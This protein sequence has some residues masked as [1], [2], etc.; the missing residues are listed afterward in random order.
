MFA[1]GE[2]V[3][4]K[5]SEL[6][7]AERSTLSKYYIIQLKLQYS[8]ILSIYVSKL[9]CS[10]DV[11]DP[12]TLCFSDCLTLT[13]LLTMVARDDRITKFRQLVESSTEEDR[14]ILE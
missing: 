4:F 9:C 2:F 6:G 10:S 1:A 13:T 3:T 14:H 5:R 8:I 11:I 12:S 7:L